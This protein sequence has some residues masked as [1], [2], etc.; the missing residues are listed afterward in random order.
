MNWSLARGCRRLRGWDRHL[1]P[2]RFY[3]QALI[4]LAAAAAVAVIATA[5]TVVVPNALPAAPSARPGTG[6]AQQGHTV[7]HALYTL[8]GRGLAAGYRGGH[9]PSAAAPRY[10]VGIR[11]LANASGPVFVTALAV[12]SAATGRVVA[13]LGQPGRG[14]YYQAVAALGGDRTFV[15]AAVPRAKQDCRTWFYRFSLGPQGRP[16]ARKPLPVPYVTGEVRYNNALAGSADGNVIAYSA[17]MCT[18]NF[19]SQVGVI[20]VA[21]GRARTWPA[22]W[23]AMPR[24]L[25]LSADG[26][27]L[28]FVG[29]P[30]SGIKAD[31]Q[32]ADAAW[33]LRTGAAPGPVASRY[34]RVLH[35]PGGVQAAELSPTGKILFAMTA[36]DPH[37]ATVSSPNVNAYHTT[38]GKL[39][40]LVQVVS[41]ASGNP[42][43]SPDGSGQHVLVY[44]VAMPFIQELNLVTG[45]LVTV[46]VSEAV[47]PFAAAW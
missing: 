20:H 32:W 23:P 17:S 8:Q 34:R 5:M 12:Y 11:Q 27:V 19:A 38:T 44:P 43:F 21:T 40:G 41:Y 24:T 42:G 46:S 4:P 30:S 35:T 13:S 3:E 31:N 2:P 16:T 29:N 15:A 22:R 36:S 47:I 37:S 7:G 25:S 1:R 9:L 10:F 45:R 14:R 18:Q 28:S 33:T 6:R 39:I 26:G